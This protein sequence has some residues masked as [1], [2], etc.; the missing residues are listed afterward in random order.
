MFGTFSGHIRWRFFPDFAQVWKATEGRQ[1]RQAISGLTPS[2]VREATVIVVWPANSVYGFGR[3]LGRLYA[4]DLGVYIFRVGNVLALLSSPLAAVLA[5]AKVAPGIG[6]RYRLT[7]R[8]LLVERGVSGRCERTLDLDRFNQIDV[9]VRP[10]QSWY[11]SGDLI[12]RLD[13]METFRIA[14]VSRP[15][16]FRQICLKSHLAHVGVSKARRAE[17]AAAS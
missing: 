16:A 11:H 12:F 1:M 6:I 14:A 5:L 3:F 4:C 7:N 13:Q 2:Q 15:E 10:G 17:A 8:R 9:D